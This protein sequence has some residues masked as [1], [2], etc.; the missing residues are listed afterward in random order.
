[1]VTMS[2]CDVPMFGL[3]QL[4]EVSVHIFCEPLPGPTSSFS[5]SNGPG[6]N[7]VLFPVRLGSFCILMR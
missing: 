4:T 3:L 2:Y 5:Q 6:Y 7:E 1:M